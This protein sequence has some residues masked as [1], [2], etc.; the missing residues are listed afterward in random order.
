MASNTMR[1]LTTGQKSIGGLLY[2]AVTSRSVSYGITIRDDVPVPS[3]EA[4]EILIQI[5]ATA[6]NPTDFKHVDLI[7]PP[8]SI[9]G[10]DYAGEVVQVGSQAGHKWKVG[11]RVAGIS[12]GG[13]YPDKGTYANFVKAEHDLA[14]KIPEGCSDVDAST[15]GVSAVTS[16]MALYHNLNVP[17]PDASASA[18]STKGSILIYAGSTAAGLF[19]IQMAKYAGWT[20]IATASPHNFDLCKKYGADSVFD[21]KSSTAVEDIKKK[22]PNVIA[23]MDCFS[24]G[25][26]TQFCADVI[27]ANG[28]KII[29]LL[30]GLRSKISGVEVQSILAYTLTGKE[31]QL[32]APLGPKYKA[33]PEDRAALARFY[34]ILPNLLDN[35]KAPPVQVLD[36]GFEALPRGLDMLRQGKVSGKKLVVEL[37]PPA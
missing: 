23:A 3:I 34:A 2:S 7:S 25:K 1:A 26:S 16:M 15:Y 20:T 8:N 33:V 28:G 22:H 30:P 17:W 32:F 24:E 13:L 37:P 6:L 5:H 27:G 10:C 14:W 35:I 31:F 9:I 19:A 29:T 18:T 4:N 21:Y 36:G 12:H 11:D